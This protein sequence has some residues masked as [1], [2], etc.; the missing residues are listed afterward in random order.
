[1][2][3]ARPMWFDGLMLVLLVAALLGIYWI[4]RGAYA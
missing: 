3:P 4:V 2:K 1:M